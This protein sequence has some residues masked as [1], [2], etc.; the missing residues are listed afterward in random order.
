MV[1]VVSVLGALA[2]LAAYT[3]NQFRLI[4]PPNVS[5]ALLN[6]VGAGVLTVIAVIE[7]QWGFLLLEGVW[8][9]VS[10]FAFVRLARGGGSPRRSH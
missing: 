1:Q 7:S 10:L 2:I 8:T 4:G 6:F 3:A 9:L 5:Y